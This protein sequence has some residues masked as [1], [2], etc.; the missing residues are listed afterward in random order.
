MQATIYLKNGHEKIWLVYKTGISQVENRSDVV[1]YNLS[2]ATDV[3]VNGGVD[4]HFYSYSLKC[5]YSPPCFFEGSLELSRS[6]ANMD[7]TLRIGYMR[8]MLLVLAARPGQ[9]HYLGIGYVPAM[10][11]LLV[12]RRGQKNCLLHYSDRNR[13]RSKLPQNSTA[14]DHDSV[15]V[16]YAMKGMDLCR[17]G[18]S[19]PMQVS[20]VISYRQVAVMAPKMVL[21]ATKLNAAME[22]KET[23]RSS[24]LGSCFSSMA[25]GAACPSL[26]TW[27]RCFLSRGAPPSPQRYLEERRL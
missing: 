19:V 10:L 23:V 2:V 1:V 24:I 20:D 26:P 18:V 5:T 4:S 22:G 17:S 14:P 3:S 7:E 8:A 12:A 21:K 27:P 16:K 11:L 9:K 6:F 15:W 13:K 25:R